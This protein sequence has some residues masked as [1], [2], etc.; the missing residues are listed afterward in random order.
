MSK[1]DLRRQRASATCAGVAIATIG[2]G[3]LSP[4]AMNAGA[5]S[6][7]TAIVKAKPNAHIFNRQGAVDHAIKW[8]NANGFFDDQP[9]PYERLHY[10]YGALSNDCM[11]FVS[12][13]WAAGGRADRVPDHWDIHEYSLFEDGLSIQDTWNSRHF[14]ASWTQVPHF[15]GFW[16]DDPTANHFATITQIPD[17]ELKGP[18]TPGVLGDV[19]LYDWGD[20]H[21]YSHAAIITAYTPP[22]S[23]LRY[24]KV[25]QHTNDRLNEPWNGTS[26]RGLI[27]DISQ[28]RPAHAKLVHVNT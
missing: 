7:H 11:N 18:R 5:V 3:V 26:T 14:T 6:R 27:Y 28:H 23:P 1:R 10:W 22:D 19:I 13:S 17:S 21:G 8:Y 16:R 12:G 9:S 4:G 25:T 20:G 24:D 15:L 2:L